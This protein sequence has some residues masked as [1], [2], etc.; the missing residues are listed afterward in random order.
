MFSQKD[1]A[2]PNKASYLPSE[3]ANAVSESIPNCLFSEQNCK[4]S[5][6]FKKLYVDISSATI[7]LE[8]VNI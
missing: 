6:I 7:E 1:T 8:L 4:L 2:I 5:S 3:I